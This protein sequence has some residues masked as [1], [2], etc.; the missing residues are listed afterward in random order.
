MV[1]LTLEIY[2]P[3]IQY[4]HRK[5]SKENLLLMCTISCGYH[6]LTNLYIDENYVQCLTAIV[7]GTEM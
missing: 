5:Q 7:S 3:L 4:E 6:M 1:V 2:A